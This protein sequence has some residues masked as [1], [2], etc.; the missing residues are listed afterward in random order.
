MDT[1]QKEIYL[2]FERIMNGDLMQLVLEVLSH[3]PHKISKKGNDYILD[4]LHD[5][6]VFMY[7]YETSL[8][9]VFTCAEAPF[10]SM[11]TD[12]AGDNV[13]FKLILH[14]NTYVIKILSDNSLCFCYASRES[15]KSYQEFTPS[16]SVIQMIEPFA[17]AFDRIRE[18]VQEENK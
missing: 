11:E 3:G 12:C 8:W 2:D 16:T 14:G 6:N 10:V 5:G 4:M 17:L 7:V 13:E 9:C 1:S 18:L 15:E